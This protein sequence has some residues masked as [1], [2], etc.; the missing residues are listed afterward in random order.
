MSD[1][2]EDPTFRLEQASESDATEL[3][4]SR[5]GSRGS[6]LPR[7]LPGTLIGIRYRIVSFLGRGGMGEVYRAEDLKLGQRVA[8]KFLPAG[9]G[10]DEAMIAQLIS[11]VRVGRRVSHPNVCRL[12]D[13]VEADGLQFLTMELVEGEDLGSLVRA[14][15]RLEESLVL[16]IAHDICSGL[17]AAHAQG[18]LHRDLKPGNVLLDG[19]GRA[20]IS[21]FGL[22]MFLKDKPQATLSGTPAYMAPEV[23]RG[24]PAS[25]Q[26]DLYSLG[27][28]LYE[29][30]TGELAFG[31]TSPRDLMLNG[32][33]PP[34]RPSQYVH[35]LDPR[36]E[37]LVL[38]CLEPDPARRPASAAWLNEH[39]P[40]ED[41]LHEALAMGLTPT[42][43]MV[44]AARGG[45]LSHRA[46]RSRRS[47]APCPRF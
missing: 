4:A 27:A 44:A 6:E 35:D 15:G 41:P 31:S 26:S 7:F 25:P 23:L 42:R 20:V 39:L 16:R 38:Q 3:L 1:D 29:L 45:A 12:H 36:V 40:G 17:A 43:A 10:A 8:L 47:S 28:L 11:E 5:P 32:R 13:F 34:V 19:M 9:F 37:R 33:T 46:T 14:S 22:A 18:V 30:L 2:A 24:A 21:D